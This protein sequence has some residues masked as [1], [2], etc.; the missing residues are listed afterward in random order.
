[1][2]V[3]VQTDVDAEQRGRLIVAHVTGLI[4]KTLE[5]YPEDD[6]RGVAVLRDW[7][8]IVTEGVTAG[9]LA[10]ETA[11]AAD[12]RE[13]RRAEQRIEYR[14]WLGG[15]RSSP[16]SRAAIQALHSTVSAGLH[17]RLDAGGAAALIGQGVAWEWD[18]LRQR[19]DDAAR[20]LL[21]LLTF[22][23][24][25]LPVRVN[26]LSDAWGAASRAATPAPPAP[27]RAAAPPHRP[28]RTWTPRS[29][30]HAQRDR[31]S[32]VCRPSG[33]PPRLSAGE[34]REFAAAL[35]RSLT[36]GL[37]SASHDHATWDEWSA[38][39]PHV[40]TL[41]EHCETL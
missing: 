28:G 12:P 17:A 22:V 7:L 38:W 35:L 30:P 3:P 1:M 19:H 9:D 33:H 23:A 40:L 14:L 37:P 36:V 21:A 26:T 32:H 31:A 16:A 24:P 34:Q 10:A 25:D 5:A 4:R 20:A 39:L 11:P 8:R 27:T 41:I 18:G 2:F 15:S 29:P 13:T 6:R